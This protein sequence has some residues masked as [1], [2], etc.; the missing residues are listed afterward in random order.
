MTTEEEI[1]Q[2]WVEVKPDD[3]NAIQEVNGKWYAPIFGCESL[4]MTVETLRADARKEI[5]DMIGENEIEIA[6][7]DY[8]ELKKTPSAIRNELRA[9]LRKKVSNL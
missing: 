4:E 1:K 8:R 6:F 7:G 5:L 3:T 2:F 9:E